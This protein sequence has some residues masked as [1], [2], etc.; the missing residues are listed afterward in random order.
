MQI[1]PTA[2]HHSRKLWLLLA[3]VLPLA[4]QTTRIPAANEITHSKRGQAGSTDKVRVGILTDTHYD[5][6]QF[7]KRADKVRAAINTFNRQGVDI[8][9]CLGDMYEGNFK[10]LDDYLADKALFEPVWRNAQAPVHWVLGNHD[11][12]GV[13]ND[14]FIKDNPYIKAFNYTFDIADHWRFVV[15]S[16]VD[17]RYFSATSS[18]LTWLRSTLNQAGREGKAVIVAAHARIDQD[19]PGTP[20]IMLKDPYSAFS[21]N[22][23]RQR[24]IINDAVASGVHVRYVLHGH[25]HQR[26]QTMSHGVT[27]LTFAPLAEGTPPAIL[28]FTQDGCAIITTKKWK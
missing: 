8:V 16:N 7:P 13:S 26:I 18:T 9:L 11:H 6:E 23:D 24:A 28:D 4:M 27:Y 17:G 14:Q 19:Y 15:Y 10:G 2:S 5:R 22:A 21:Y 3:I 1:K 25:Q 20:P 12:W